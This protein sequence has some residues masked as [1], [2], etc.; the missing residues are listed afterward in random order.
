MKL[1]K[2]NQQQ[3]RAQN[4]QL[5]LQTIYDQFETSRVDVARQTGLTRTTVSDLV[6][7]LLTEGLVEET[8]QGQSNGG[9][10]PTLLKFIDDR[11][12]LISVDLASHEF[13]GAVV[14]LRGQ[15][16]H[17]ACLRVGD[18]KGDDALNLVF[19]LVDTLI[20]HAT[21]PIIGIG[22][23]SPGLI[24]PSSGTV[25]YAVNL[26]WRDLP[27]AQLIR[28]RYNLPVHVANNSQAAA[29]A[30]TTFGIH[31]DLPN[32][33]VIKIGRGI[34][35]RIVINGQPFFGDGPYAGEIGHVVV[36]ENG[37]Q[38]ACGK[39]GCLETV[40]SSR[41][42]LKRAQNIALQNPSSILNQLAEDPCSITL[43]IV[44]QACLLGDP[45]VNQLIDEVS[46]YLGMAIANLV[47]AINIK[48][49]MIAGIITELGDVLINSLERQLSQHTLSSLAKETHIETS[50][51]GKD[52]VIQGISA[53]LIQ[54]ELGIY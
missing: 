18:S 24:D 42:I 21:I 31:R 11:S 5:V 41:V 9:K 26:D 10:R 15:I 38:C 43:D 4:R 13:Q 2:G 51:L 40:A 48:Q 44:R 45:Q 29:F 19:E 34:A 50:Q 16:I 8:G 3:T 47:C 6:S 53:L 36:K 22:I 27:L 52:I 17:K 20:A 35:A 37:D 30:E 28:E 39:H 46:S 23:G 25:D 32:M 7:E 49:V 12:C 1:L 14:N 33:I 54:R